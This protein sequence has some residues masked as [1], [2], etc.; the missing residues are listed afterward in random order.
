MPQRPPIHR[1]HGEPSRR[2]YDRYYDAVKRNRAARDVYKTAR[3]QRFRHL[4]L[5]RDGY[6]CVRCNER[7]VLRPAD[8]VHHIVKITEDESRAFDMDNCISLCTAC[9]AREE[10]RGT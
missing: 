10:K 4:V 6:L 8:Q 1:P 7:G 3:W 2:V 9:H 5:D